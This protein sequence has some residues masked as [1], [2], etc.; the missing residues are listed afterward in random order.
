MSRIC[1]VC[2]RGPNQANLRSH[3]NVAS[4]RRQMVNLQTKKI[5]GQKVKSCTRCLRTLAK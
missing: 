1:D 2:G 3:S 5:D 4:K